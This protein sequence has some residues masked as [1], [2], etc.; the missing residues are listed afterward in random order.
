MAN[1]AF[2]YTGNTPLPSAGRVPQFVYAEADAAKPA[3]CAEG[4]TCYAADTNAWYLATAANTW[5]LQGGGGSVARES[6]VGM[7][8]EPSTKSNVG[9]A[10]VDVYTDANS[11][12]RPVWVDF[13]GK[14]Q[15]AASI[16]WDKIGAGTHNV[17]VVDA[18]DVANVLFDVAVVS[19]DNAV[20]LAAL[21][22]WATGVKRLKIQCK[23]TTSTDDPVF[24]GCSIRLK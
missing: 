3:T 6:L 10:F 22:A 5:A 16:Q 24:R 17:R 18:D 9:T 14:S 4:D 8:T 7:W 12:G 13:A 20:A 15:F 1:Y 2:T 21:P 11:A 19:G 23:S